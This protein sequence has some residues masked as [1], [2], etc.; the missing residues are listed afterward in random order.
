MTRGLEHL[1]YGERLRE[2][3]LFSTKRRLRRDLINV[4]KNL[5]GEDEEEGARFFSVVP[6]TG[7]EAVG[8]D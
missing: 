6:V 4:Y 7:Q 8:T 2:L 1:S 3:R 5:M